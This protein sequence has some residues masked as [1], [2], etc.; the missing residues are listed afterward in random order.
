MKSV[1]LS[2]KTKISRFFC[3]ISQ[4]TKIFEELYTTIRVFMTKFKWNEEPLTECH[5]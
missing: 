5:R 3:N 2:V 4:L 1:I